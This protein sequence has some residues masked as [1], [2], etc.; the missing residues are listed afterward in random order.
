MPEEVF[1][2]LQSLGAASGLGQAALITGLFIVLI[3]RPERIRSRTLF[4]LACWSLGLSILFPALTNP[5]LGALGAGLF[6]GA[7]GY[8][9]SGGFSLISV[10]ASGCGA[11]L[12]GLSVLLGLLSLVPGPRQTSPFQ[13]P[14]HPLE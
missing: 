6:A 3:F 7:R 2:L 10:V 12:Y 9:G 1:Y 13:P 5:F 8:P 11:A 4:S 14:K